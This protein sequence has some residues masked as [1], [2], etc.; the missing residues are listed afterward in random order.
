LTFL[1]DT[2]VFS[3]LRKGRNA[4][5][6]AADWASSILEDRIFLSVVTLYE[7]ER[8]ILGAEKRERPEAVI[9]R[10]WFDRELRPGYLSRTLPITDEIAVQAAVFAVDR[11]VELADQL[12]AATASV[13]G[14]TL[15]TR[16]EKHFTR[17]GV[18]LFNPFT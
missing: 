2:N 9:L 16:N 12:I 15:V 10:S 14:L 6:G 5:A 3:E 7:I 8:G 4:N 11:T 1:F 18:R 13:N 17:T